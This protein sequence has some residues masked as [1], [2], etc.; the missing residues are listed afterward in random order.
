MRFRT[1]LALAA[2][3]A[4]AAMPTINLL[5]QDGNAEPKN[6]GGGGGGGAYLSLNNGNN[7]ETAGSFSARY[8]RGYARA[9][10]REHGLADFP[11]AAADG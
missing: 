6:N 10:E 11:A 7:Q 1:A 2:L 5:K 4:L 3:F 8:A 9:V